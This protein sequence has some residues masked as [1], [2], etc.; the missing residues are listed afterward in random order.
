MSWV[1][2][3]CICIYI[4]YIDRKII[5]ALDAI[6]FSSFNDNSLKSKICWLSVLKAATDFTVSKYIDAAE[7]GKLYFSFPL[8]EI[9]RTTFL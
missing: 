7:D 2:M 5:N 3:L 8:K 1:T 6:I 4:P 9:S